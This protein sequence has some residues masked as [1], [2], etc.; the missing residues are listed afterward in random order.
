MRI[1]ASV[2][3]DVLPTEYRD[4]IVRGMRGVLDSLDG[5]DP[6]VAIARMKAAAREADLDARAANFSK[7]AQERKDPEI[8]AR[9]L[10][11]DPAQKAY[12][13]RQ[14]ID[15]LPG[16]R[17]AADQSYMTRVRG[18]VGIMQGRLNEVIARLT[19]GF[20]IRPTKYADELRRGLLGLATDDPQVAADVKLIRETFQP[21]LKRLQQAGVHVAEVENW[22][23]RDWD[24]AR[25]LSNESR[26]DELMARGLSKEVHPDP[27]ATVARMKYS[28]SE[29]DTSGSKNLGIGMRRKIM[30]DDPEIEY[31]MMK[32]FGRGD[33]SAQLLRVIDTLSQ[34]VTA[35]EMLGPLWRQKV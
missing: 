31:L 24:L 29:R 13:L 27:G 8:T 4:E 25:I 34:E 18:E 5:K 3:S 6:A 19:E 14:F 23:M 1:M 2:S 22:W 15:P 10:E 11:G 21:Y 30:F 28:L 16:N 17:G 9:F 26:F 20:Y 7:L 32:E 33:L 35:S 12:E